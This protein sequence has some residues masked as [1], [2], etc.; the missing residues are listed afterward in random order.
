MKNYNFGLDEIFK[1]A[2]PPQKIIWNEVCL[3]AGDTFS[4]QPVYI[5]KGA[6]TVFETFTARTLW[7]AYSMYI[8]S[9]VAGG[10]P[11]DGY[12][13]IYDYLNA[14]TINLRLSQFIG[15]AYEDFYFGQIENIMF[16]RIAL[17]NYNG[18]IFTGFKIV[19]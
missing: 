7:F 9:A 11:P 2:T 16:G 17:T 12:C 14:A 13:A 19:Y 4:I 8:G 10:A 1:S 5:N 18:V 6:P 15:G 3:I